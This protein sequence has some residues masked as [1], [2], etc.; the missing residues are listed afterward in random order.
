MSTEAYNLNDLI[1]MHGLPDA[2]IDSY[3]SEWGYAVWG[4]EDI[5]SY[6]DN[7]E[8]P[9]N[10]LQNFFDNQSEDD[11]DIK[12]LGFLSYDIK[13]IVYPHIE[14]KSIQTDF[15]YIWFGK[16]KKVRRYIVKNSTKYTGSRLLSL[17]DN[18]KDISDYKNI[19][20]KIKKELRAGNTYQINF[21][22]E[23]IFQIHAR[24]I[25]IYL[26]IREYAQPQYGYFLNIGSHQVLSFSPEDFFHT[27]NNIIYTS[28]MKGTIKRGGDQASDKLF[29][30]T[31][32]N[33]KKNKSEHIMIVDLLR[34]DLGKI[35]K[36]GTIDVKNLF[37][38]K[39]YP[40]VH[41]MVSCVYGDLKA[42][43][44]Y[45]DIFKALCPGGSITGAPKESSMKII[46][47]LEDYN[48]G[49]YTGTI[50][51][52]DCNGD[53]HFNMAIRT[54]MVKESIAKYGVGGGIVWDSDAIEEWHEAELKSKIL[55]QF[56]GEK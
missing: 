27:K 25:D 31:L 47:S 6:I 13:D 24:P 11:S 2:L 35:C 19:I 50:G 22:M 38:I 23:K 18:I 34:N 41:Q 43:I 4:F 10:A 45:T 28:P 12:A 52:I 1:D 16:P 30:E 17:I 15:P 56:I 55:D 33:C 54:M 40:T 29:K 49:I 20:Q 46:D 44:E 3:S 32:K 14:F 21:T 39:S 8:N 42:N 7:T 36:Y 51:H 48:R 37:E 26:S 9:F 5:Y 53:M